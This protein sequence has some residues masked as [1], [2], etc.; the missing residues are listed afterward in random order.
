MTAPHRTHIFDVSDFMV[1]PMLSDPGNASPTYGAPQDVPGVATV[2]VAS[3]L[4]TATLKGDA[5]I[6]DRKSRLDGVTLN[7][8][9]GSVDVDVNKI[10]YKGY[11]TSGGSGTNEWVRWGTTGGQFLPVFAARFVIDDVDLGLDA[12][13]CT[14][15]KATISGGQL[16]GGASDNYNQPTADMAAFQS[17]HLTLTPDDGGVP[18][19]DFTPLIDVALWETLINPFTTLP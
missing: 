7:V 1:W 8:T 9:Y 6:L 10:L 16:L 2:T 4:I 11:Q 17:N 5:R 18:F 14:V 19:Q 15:Y 12:V 3:D 13:V